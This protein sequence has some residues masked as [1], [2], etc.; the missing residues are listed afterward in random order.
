[1]LALA[2]ALALLADELTPQKAAQVQHD[3]EKALAAIAQKYGNKPSSELSQDERREMIRDQRAAE[4]A[5]LAKNGVDA[6]AMARY[7]AT[8]SLS[9]R[10]A[11]KNEK[12]RLEKKD[13]DDKQA[14]EERER[15]SKEVPIQRGFSEDNPVTVEQNGESG[16][17][18]V[19]NGLP[20]EA[21]DD[22]AA[23][24]NADPSGAPKTK[25]KGARKRGKAP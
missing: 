1:M 7:E 2:L 4:D 24:S 10:A 12:Q 22:Q 18:A 8:L 16:P 25:G 19:E 14:A 17:P 9:E 21:L 6:K 11:E 15:K 5:V 23:A 13:A 3:R 20:Q